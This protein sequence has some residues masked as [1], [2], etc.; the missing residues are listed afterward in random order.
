MSVIFVS[1]ATVV[2]EKIAKTLI[3]TASFD[4]K[5]DFS[6]TMCI[7]VYKQRKYITKHLVFVMETH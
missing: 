2:A 5:T 6:T 7:Y 4:K 1:L 3:S